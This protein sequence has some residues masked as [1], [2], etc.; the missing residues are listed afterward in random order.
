MRAAPRVYNAYIYVRT[1]M[2]MYM[3]VHVRMRPPRTSLHCKKS[4][5]HIYILRHMTILN[6]AHPLLTL[7][8]WN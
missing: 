5:A 1:C 3:Y 4:R 8:L 2:Y 7:E 6:I